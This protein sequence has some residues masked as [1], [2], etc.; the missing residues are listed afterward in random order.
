ME[1]NRHFL[2]RL[3]WQLDRQLD[4][5][6]WHKRRRW[7]GTTLWNGGTG[8]NTD[9]F[10]VNATVSAWDLSRISF[11]SDS[12]QNS[13]VGNGYQIMSGSCANQI[14]PI[15]KPVAYATAIIL[16]IGGLI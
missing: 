13:F 10:Y 9:K 15:L 6:E 16:L 5:V 12:L 2:R 8:N 7:T 1:F 14:N 3:Q 4:L 11:F